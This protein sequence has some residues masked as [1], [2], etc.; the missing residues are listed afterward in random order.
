MI[1][2]REILS[3]GVEKMKEIKTKDEKLKQ[4]WRK[5][6]SMTILITKDDKLM[7]RVRKVEKKLVSTIWKVKKFM[8]RVRRIKNVCHQ[9]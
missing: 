3:I 4:R 6:M 7:P 5:F 9:R 1:T 8:P 2:I